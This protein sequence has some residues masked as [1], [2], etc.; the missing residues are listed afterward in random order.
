[1]ESDATTLCWVILSEADDHGGYDIRHVLPLLRRRPIQ[2]FVTELEE[3]ARRVC[4]IIGGKPQGLLRRIYG[5]P[6]SES[7][8]F[9]AAVTRVA[10]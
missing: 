3:N 7:R 1:M 8:S 4:N 9:L 10:R 5:R 6:Y 2:Q